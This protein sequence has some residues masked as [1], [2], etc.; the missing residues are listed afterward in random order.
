M[1]SVFRRNGNGPWL[2]H[3]FDEHGRRR[4]KSSRTTDRRPAERIASTLEADV[5]L[6]RE[7]VVDAR[8]DRLTEEN[9][10]PLAQHIREYVEHCRGRG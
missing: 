2:I 5:A 4:E 3:Y 9:R 8:Q 10:K 7:G 6:R 1:P